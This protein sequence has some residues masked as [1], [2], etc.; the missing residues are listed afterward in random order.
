MYVGLHILFLGDSSELH[1]NDGG[2]AGSAA[3]DC[4]GERE[5][6]AGGREEPTHT[7]VCPEQEVCTY[8]HTCRHM[9]KHVFSILAKE[10]KNPKDHHYQT[11]PTHHALKT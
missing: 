2:S 5:T 7:A 11:L 10:R 6:R 9:E 4:S 8:V 3:G 1:D